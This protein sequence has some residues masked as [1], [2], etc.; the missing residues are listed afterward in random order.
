MSRPVI[1][2]FLNKELNMTVG[3]ASAQAAH[4]AAMSVINSPQES[5]SRWEDAVHRTVIVLEARN[6]E[7]LKNISEY[8][9][10]RRLHVLK[11]IDEGANEVDP[12]TWTALATQILEKENEHVEQTFSTFKLYRDAIRVVLEMEK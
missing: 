11:I 5:V 2:I 6:N 9:E 7:H 12:H 3:K 4:A 10:Q 1:Y 8:L